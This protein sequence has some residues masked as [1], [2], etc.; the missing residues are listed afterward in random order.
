ME[1]DKD[2]KCMRDEEQNISGLLVVVP[3]IYKTSAHVCCET[4]EE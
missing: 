3:P 1:A 4:L 2:Y